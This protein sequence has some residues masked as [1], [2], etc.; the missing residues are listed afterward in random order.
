[1]IIVTK[2]RTTQSCQSCSHW[3]EIWWHWKVSIVC[4]CLHK[5]RAEK[6]TIVCVFLNKLLLTTRVT[7]FCQSLVF[8]LIVFLQQPPPQSPKT[9]MPSG[10]SYA[11]QP[12]KVNLS[13][14]GG[15][16][17]EFGS[18]YTAYRP[19]YTQPVTIQTSAV[20][21]G[22]QHAEMLNRVQESLDNI[23]L[24]PRTPDQ[25]QVTRTCLIDYWENGMVWK[26]MKSNISVWLMLTTWFWRFKFY[27]TFW[28][29]NI[30]MFFFS[31]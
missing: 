20:Q 24:S 8:T 29:L 22:Q 21:R 13:K 16:G 15:G 30:K 28:I 10:G 19:S 5:V 6:F 25:Y 14:L 31:S 2:T 11:F 17:P 26:Q 9:Q 18:D 23:T 3:G 7:P 4:N 1:M 27:L 12:K